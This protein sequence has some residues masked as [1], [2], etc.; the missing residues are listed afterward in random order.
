MVLYFELV[1]VV[2]LNGMNLFDC[3][4]VVVVGVVVVIVEYVVVVVV[5]VDDGVVDDVEFVDV[6]V[7]VKM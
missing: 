6:V 2:V 5:I 7:G 4:L 3:L 1:F